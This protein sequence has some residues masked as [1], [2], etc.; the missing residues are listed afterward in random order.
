[1]GEL[2]HA[3]IVSFRESWIEKG[4][5]VCIVTAY[6]D[7][8]DLM[9]RLQRSD[10]RLYPEQ[11]VLGWFAQLTL[12]LDYLHSRRILHRDIKSSKCARSAGLSLTSAPSAM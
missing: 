7:G 9:S 1:M 4:V 10:G 8:G 6:C 11:R 12:A 5:C 2:R 3:N